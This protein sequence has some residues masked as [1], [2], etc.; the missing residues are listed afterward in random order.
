MS[1]KIK[2]ACFIGSTGQGKSSTANSLCGEMK[3]KTSNA[4][5]SETA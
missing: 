5:I 1:S 4:M 3:F 2:V